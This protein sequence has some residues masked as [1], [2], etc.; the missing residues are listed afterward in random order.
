MCDRAYIKGDIVLGTTL[1][2]QPCA[3]AEQDCYSTEETSYELREADSKQLAALRAPLISGLKA[4]W[5]KGKKQ[6]TLRAAEIDVLRYLST[7]VRLVDIKSLVSLPEVHQTPTPCELRGAHFDQRAA[8]MAPLTS[9]L[10][11]ILTKAEEQNT[12]ADEEIDLLQRL[13]TLVRLADLESL[14]RLQRVHNLMPPEWWD[15]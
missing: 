5:T 4:I 3:S 7:L 2:A 9:G 14:T 8:M 1:D 11:A 10:K 15:A 6:D 12:L 13:S